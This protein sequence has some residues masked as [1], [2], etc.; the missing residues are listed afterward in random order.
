MTSTETVEEPSSKV[1]PRCLSLVSVAS[2]LVAVVGALLATVVYQKVAFS[3][4]DGLRDYY[5]LDSPNA[6]AFDEWRDSDTP[7]GPLIL[8]DFYV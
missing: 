3:L 7:G 4:S 2:L 5:V 8:T 6:G 1:S